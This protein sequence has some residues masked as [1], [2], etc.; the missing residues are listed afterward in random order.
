MCVAIEHRYKSMR[1]D[2]LQNLEL[3]ELQKHL[4]LGSRRY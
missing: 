3:S 2:V 1:P 4:P